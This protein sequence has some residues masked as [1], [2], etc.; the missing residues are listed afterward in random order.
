VQSRPSVI[1]AAAHRLLAGL[2]LLFVA[3]PAEAQG[4]RDRGGR[5]DTPGVFDFYVLALSWS[6][7]FCQTEAGRRSQ[8]Q[9][10][11]RQRSEFVIHGLW[12]QHERGYPSNCSA[13][14]RPI[15]RAAMEKAADLFPDERLA[16]Y[17]WNKHGTCS[18]KGPSEYF[19]DVAE[20]RAKVVI[21]RLFE[22]P[23]RDIETSPQEIERAFVDANRGLRVD[24]MSVQC[25]RGQV[26]EVRL[27]LSKDLRAFTPCVE[28]NRSSCRSR[29]VSLPAAR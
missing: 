18:G 8:T 24:M 14:N 25:K 29:E 22:R 1:P 23:N 28:V 27:C 11:F 26:T 13:V 12:P 5:G 21:P 6:P 9:C 15:P 7:S 10:G 17:E 19:D 20:A 16:R 2:L 3:L 4:F